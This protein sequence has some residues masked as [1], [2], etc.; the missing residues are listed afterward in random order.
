MENQTKQVNDGQAGD[1]HQTGRSRRSEAEPE[2]NIA[3][4]VIDA[5]LKYA[6]I[7]STENLN[8]LLGE[9]T[10]GIAELDARTG[11]SSEA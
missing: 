6:A 3:Q 11:M 10:A 1:G 7:G 5:L 9:L 8:S 2:K 4:S